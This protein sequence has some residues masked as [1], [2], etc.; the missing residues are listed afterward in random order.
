MAEGVSYRHHTRL[1]LAVPVTIIGKD[2]AGQPH[3]EDTKTVDVG[4]RGARIPL[5][6]APPAKAG[7]GVRNAAGGEAHPARVVWRGGKKD[8]DGRTEIGVEFLRPV[9]AERLWAI[10]SPPEDWGNKQL[11]L[12]TE[13]KLELIAERSLVPG[14]PHVALP[15]LSEIVPFGGPGAGAAADVQPLIYF[16]PIINGLEEA[17]S[18]APPAGL[19]FGVPPASASLPSTSLRDGALSRT[20]GVPTPGRREDFPQ[21]PDSAQEL[22]ARLAEIL[23]ERANLSLPAA[24]DPAGAIRSAEKEAV[25]ELGAQRKKIEE[26]LRATSQHYEK[27]LETLGD[28]SLERLRGSSQRLLAA[29]REELEKALD[30]LEKKAQAV[31]TVHGA[32]KE[33]VKT[34]ENLRR[35]IEVRLQASYGES[36]KQLGALAASSLEDLARK[37]QAMLGGFQEELGKAQRQLEDTAAGAVEH[38]FAK[39]VSEFKGELAALG[40]QQDQR[41]KALRAEMEDHVR[42]SIPKV[43]PPPPFEPRTLLPPV[44]WTAG[45]LAALSVIAF[46]VFVYSSTVRVW[47][48]RPD[49]PSEFFQTDPSW[50]AGRLAMEQQLAAGYWDQAVRVLQPAFPFGTDLPEQPPSYFWLDPQ[51]IDDVRLRPNAEASRQR[52]WQ[53]LR[54]IWSDS[55][56]WNESYEWNTKWL[57]SRLEPLGEALRKLVS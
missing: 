27:E 7:I 57:G 38:K 44:L 43:E 5:L 53:I 1:L 45:A 52:Y 49:L 21:P 40:R 50:N 33:A 35:Q 42:D 39:L 47:R 51:R 18:G 37:S 10:A 56:K 2:G 30:E 4:K 32:E 23:T 31:G 8:L 12:S 55:G 14:Q 34:L 16:E 41:I 26:A 9:D 20:L 6:K 36:Q 3:H 25:D 29:F 28:A 11:S 24:S 46:L 54:K 13:E 48:L 17:G 22:A 15:V 19:P